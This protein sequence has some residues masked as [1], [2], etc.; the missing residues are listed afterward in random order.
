LLK[1][2]QI[3]L[4]I[5]FLDQ[6]LKLSP[7]DPEVVYTLVLAH[8]ENNNDEEYEKQALRAIERTP[9]DR[10]IN[11]RLALVK[12]YLNK[13]MHGKILGLLSPLKDI[14]SEKYPSEQIADVVNFAW[15]FL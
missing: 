13:Q 1:A 4:A 7:N 2:N 9:F 11:Q 10:A 14:E 8:R 5:Q 6:L 15:P 3:D 12:Y